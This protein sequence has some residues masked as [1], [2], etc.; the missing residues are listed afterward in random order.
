MEEKFKIELLPDAV[1]FME[2][3]DE[4]TRQKIYY[5][6]KKAQIINDKELFKKLNE[7]IWEFRT[8]YQSN[9][10]RLFAFYRGSFCSAFEFSNHRTNRTNFRILRWHN[11]SGFRFECFAEID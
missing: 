9:A 3:L 7:H 1:D 4:K 6:L 11:A 10:Y 8:L 2:N 5:N